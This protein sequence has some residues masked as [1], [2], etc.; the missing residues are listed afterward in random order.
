M[1]KAAQLETPREEPEAKT[2]DAPSKRARTRISAVSLN[3]LSEDSGT[4]QDIQ[5]F[6]DAAKRLFPEYV[7]EVTGEKHEQYD[8]VTKEL[9]KLN[10][11]NKQCGYQKH[12]GLVLKE[13]QLAECMEDSAREETEY[14]VV[15]VTPVKDEDELDAL[16]D[17]S[18]DFYNSQGVVDRKRDES[19]DA[20]VRRLLVA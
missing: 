17:M 7:M 20:F 2:D 8:I 10:R 11:E 15:I 12:Y 3:V 14:F 16:T 1:E 4:A 13:A 5:A 6:Y 19:M 18:A 9:K